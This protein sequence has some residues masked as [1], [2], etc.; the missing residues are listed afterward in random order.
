M[1]QPLKRAPGT[2]LACSWPSGERRTQLVTQ[3]VELTKRGHM[4]QYYLGCLHEQNPPDLLLQCAV[5]AQRSGFA[6]VSPLATTFSLG[7]NRGNPGRP[8]CGWAR[9]CKRRR[10]CHSARR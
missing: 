1:W 2:N 5:E 9:R 7:G 3:G 8:L 10:S 4:A 6:G